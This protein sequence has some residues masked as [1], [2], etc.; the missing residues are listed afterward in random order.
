MTNTPWN[1]HTPVPHASDCMSACGPAPPPHSPF[2]PTHSPTL[3]HTPQVVVLKKRDFLD[4]DNPLLAWMLDYDAVNA[5][6]R[7]L[8]AFKRLRP[9][10]LEHILDRCDARQELY[11]GQAVLKQGDSV[12]GLAGGGGVRGGVWR[13]AGRAC[14]K[15]RCAH[16]VGQIGGWAGRRRGCAC[17]WEQGGFGGG[18]CA[19]QHDSSMPVGQRSLGSHYPLP[20][21]ACLASA[22]E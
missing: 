6:L 10:A 4:L 12:G 18:W 8:P 20:S 9:D 15:G 17:V 3:T 7:S 21:P 13:G 5:V 22:S 16:A 19:T 14:R 2:L 11:Q 1:T